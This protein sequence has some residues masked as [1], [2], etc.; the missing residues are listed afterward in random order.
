MDLVRAVGSLVLVIVALVI[1]VMATL[2]IRSGTGD[3]Q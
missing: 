1:C 3:G 2:R